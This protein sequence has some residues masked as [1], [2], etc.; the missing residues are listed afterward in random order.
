MDMTTT[1]ECKQ[2]HVTTITGPQA[3]ALLELQAQGLCSSWLDKSVPG[4]A[5]VEI[6][7]DEED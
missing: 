1:Q 5:I 3:E 4:M 6:W 2:R 7:A